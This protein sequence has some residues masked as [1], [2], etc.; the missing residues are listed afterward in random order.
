MI[1]KRL[2]YVWVGG[3]LPERYR[4]N[5][6]GWRRLNPG[7]EVVGWDENNIDF[8]HPLLAEAYRN[9]KWSKV[10]DIARLRA[11]LEQG[12]VYLDTDFTVVRPLDPVLRHRC[13]FAFQGAAKRS[14]MVANGC[15]GA[16][17][18]HWFVREALEAVLRLRTIPFNLERPTRYG[19]K[20][21]TRLLRAHGL[22]AE[23]PEATQLRDIHIYPAP[24]FFPYP[25]QGVFTPECVRENTLAVH[26]WGAS[27]KRPAP[28]ALR[29]AAGLLRQLPGRQAGRRQPRTKRA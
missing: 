15:F 29:R 11:V 26:H 25:Y 23:T 18:G 17:A 19:P 4:A 16:E 12:G 2:H 10:S 3:P 5:L 6:E 22:A 13:F 7:W 9:R 14:D 8:S 27:W 21:V 1:P 28:W 24:V 20:L